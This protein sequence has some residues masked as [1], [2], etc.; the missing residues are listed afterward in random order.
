[1]A[2]WNIELHKWYENQK[3]FS[4]IDQLSKKTRIPKSNLINYLSGEIENR[5]KISEGHLE[6]LYQITDL[7]CLDPERWFLPSDNFY[8]IDHKKHPIKSFFYFL[9]CLADC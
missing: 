2:D 3:D 9:G 8:S 1:M 7:E 4:T 6:K 5:N